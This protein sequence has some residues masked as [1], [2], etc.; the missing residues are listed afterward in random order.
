M[1]ALTIFK[2]LVAY[3]TTIT[4]NLVFYESIITVAFVALLSK[5]HFDTQYEI[6]FIQHLVFIN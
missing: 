2:Y 1:D 3:Y 5:N 6:W 4:T